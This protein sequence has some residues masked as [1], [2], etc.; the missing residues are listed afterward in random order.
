MSESMLEMRLNQLGTQEAYD[1]MENKVITPLKQMDT[2]LMTPQRDALDGLG[3][4]T[5]VED[6]I[7]REDQIIAKM[8]E[9]LKQM[10]Q[11]DSFVDVL[12][13]LNEIIRMQESVK[14]GTEGLKSKQVEGVFDK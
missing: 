13:Q 12:N 11:W 3:K 1:L 6:A 4:E 2:D 7:G 9:I 14:V 8:Q 10:S 5:K